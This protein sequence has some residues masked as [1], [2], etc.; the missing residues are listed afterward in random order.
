MC[1]FP[2]GVEGYGEAL[3]IVDICKEINKLK[4]SK[5]VIVFFFKEPFLEWTTDFW[6]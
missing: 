2:K 1:V 3:I 5:N 6:D 4:Y